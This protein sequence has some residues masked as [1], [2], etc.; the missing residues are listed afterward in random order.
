MK[1]QVFI[2]I[3][4][5]LLG[6]L[7]SLGGCI[8]HPPTAPLFYQVHDPSRVHAPAPFFLTIEEAQTFANKMNKESENN[9]QVS[10][11]AR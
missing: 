5:V 1:M 11:I 6:I 3:V 2:L 10:F 4:V 9:Y 8:Y 7:L